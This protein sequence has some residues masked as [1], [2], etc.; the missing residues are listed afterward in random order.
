MAE[1]ICLNDGNRI[2]D[3]RRSD[4]IFCCDKCGWTYR[5]KNYKEANFEMKVHA[6]N[7]KM[8]HKVLQTLE[9]K[10]KYD[11]SI[12]AMEL[13][14]FD[15]EYCTKIESINPIEEI[16]EYHLYEYYLIVD[17]SRCKFKRRTL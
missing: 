8:N 9:S 15:F 5:N 4:A 11:V 1:K 12:E 13:M 2:P 10:G 6:R 17:K 16:M 14:D 3:H 7:L